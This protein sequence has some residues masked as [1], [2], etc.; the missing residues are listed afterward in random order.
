M[1]MTGLLLYGGIALS[2]KIKISIDPE[3][4]PFIFIMGKKQNSVRFLKSP[5]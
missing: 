4:F 5:L 3:T 2:E 1:D